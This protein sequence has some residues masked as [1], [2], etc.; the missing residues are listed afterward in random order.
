MSVGAEFIEH[1]REEHPDDPRLMFAQYL[2]SGQSEVH[3]YVHLNPMEGVP[4]LL[5]DHLRYEHPL[6]HVPYREE[7]PVLSESVARMVKCT[8]ELHAQVVQSLRGDHN[9]TNA[10]L[11]FQLAS[12]V[13][14]ISTVIEMLAQTSST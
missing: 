2:M 13:E 6:A 1:F 14:A 7:A 11:I 12:S 5:H 9:I 4:A 3:R 10:Q 8:D